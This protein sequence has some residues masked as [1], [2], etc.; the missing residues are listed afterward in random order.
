M[1]SKLEARRADE[2][3]SCQLER[4]ENLGSLHGIRHAISTRFGG[5]SRTPYSGLNLGLHVGDDP[6][7]VQE[8]R[9]IFAQEAGFDIGD[10]VF[11]QQTHG[12]KVHRLLASD[13]GR[14]FLDQADT[15]QD[16]D[17]FITDE[18]RV[19]P[20]ILTADC[21]PILLADPVRGAIGAVH[22]G[23]RGTAG[24]IAQITVESMVREFGCRPQDIWAGIGPSIGPDDFEV[25]PELAKIFAQLGSELDR[26]LVRQASNTRPHPTSDATGL[27]SDRSYVDLWAANAG[28]LEL[29]GVPAAQIEVTGISTMRFEKN[30]PDEPTIEAHRNFASGMPAGEPE[31]GP[32]LS[33]GAETGDQHESSARS[34]ASRYYSYRSEGPDCGRFG[35]AIGL[36]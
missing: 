18:R 35:I 12:V 6:A 8:N 32:D 17:A 29:A 10:L 7:V 27:E 36:E 30:V 5:R 1:D 22:A 34:G 20:V 31:H 16:T 23:W 25:G 33:L 13:R 21:V 2:S 11:G 3:E 24:R 26:P 28:L 9:R 15:I 4:F 14:G 19:V